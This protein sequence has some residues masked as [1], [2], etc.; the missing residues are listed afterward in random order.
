[1]LEGARSGQLAY[2]ENTALVLYKHPRQ[3][4]HPIACWF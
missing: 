4:I 1:M 2:K 3:I